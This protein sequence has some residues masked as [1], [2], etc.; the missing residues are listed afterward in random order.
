MSD[1]ENFYELV[2]SGN[3]DFDHNFEATAKCG[4]CKMDSGEAQELRDGSFICRACFDKIANHIAQK[5]EEDL[6]ERQREQKIED[7]REAEERDSQM[8]EKQIK[9]DESGDYRL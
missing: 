9:M 6:S 8:H 3:Y 2:S 1:A 7:Q 5:N 4:H